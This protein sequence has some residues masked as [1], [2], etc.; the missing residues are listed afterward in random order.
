M[1]CFTQLW[2]CKSASKNQPKWPQVISLRKVVQFSD[3][4]TTKV[5]IDIF[6]LKDKPL[7]SLECYLNAFDKKDSSFD[8]SGAFECRLTSLFDDYY[9]H[10]TLLTAEE[11]Q[12][13][14]W[15]SR[16]VFQISELECMMV[17][18]EC[19]EYP[20]YGRV[21]RFRLRGMDLSL[22]IKNYELDSHPNEKEQLRKKRFKWL[23]L[24]IIVVPNPDAISDVAL[25]INYDDKL[26]SRIK[27]PKPAEVKKIVQLAGH[28]MFNLDLTSKTGVRLYKLQCVLNPTDEDSNDE[29]DFSGAFFCRLTSYYDNRQSTLLT[30]NQYPTRDWENRGQFLIEQITG[31]CATYPDYGR[32]RTFTLRGMN[33]TLTID[34]LRISAGSIVNRTSA[35]ESIQE[36]ALEITISSDTT[37]ISEIAMP[38]KYVELLVPDPNNPDKLVR[39]CSKIRTK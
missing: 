22:E 7:Y 14:D 5:K 24:E 31:D 3:K 26:Y 12:T 19:I 18:G 29:F 38:S 15:D 6:G 27:W 21:R 30:E 35:E 10:R 2:T 36:L 39:D 1:C 20:G 17:D 34:H 32:S 4:E 11:H 33:L 28:Q 13:R 16:G 37:A 23:E 9:P 25:P 8:Y